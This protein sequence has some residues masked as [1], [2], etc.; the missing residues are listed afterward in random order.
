[1][2]RPQLPLAVAWS[3]GTRDPIRG[4]ILKMLRGYL[5]RYARQKRKEVGLKSNCNLRG[6]AASDAKRTFA[7]AVTSEK[8][9]KQ[10]H[11]PQHSAARETLAA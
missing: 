6:T 1:M 7:K 9:H 3:S 2:R 8:C 5:S 4:V 10:T 11:A